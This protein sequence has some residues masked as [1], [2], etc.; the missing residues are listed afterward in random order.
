MRNFNAPMK[1]PI[2][3]IL[4]SLTLVFQACGQT[5]TTKPSDNSKKNKYTNSTYR[6]TVNIPDNWKL[7]GQIKNDTVNHKAIA[8]WGLPSTYSELEKTDIENSISIKAYHRTDILS[9]E[10][11]ISFEYLRINPTET[12]LEKD[13]INSNA[14]I[15]YSTKNG[16]KF[17]G[18]SYYVFR[19]NIGYVVTF[20]ATPGT[21]DKHIKVFEN[22]YSTIKYL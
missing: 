18:K 4:C 12:A 7:Y 15:I 14:R 21:Y 2:L 9:L 19:N 8:D 13:P 5:Q 6:F 22:F 1:L 16:H 11:L 3:Y 10:Q 17:K 20:M